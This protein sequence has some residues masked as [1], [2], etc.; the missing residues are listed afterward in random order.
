MRW[1]SV[2]FASRRPPLGK[3]PRAVRTVAAL[4]VLLLLFSTTRS[5]ASELK[6]GTVRAWDDYVRTVNLATEER[7]TGHSPFLWVDESPDLVRRVRGGEVLV[8]GY[9]LQKVSH[10]LIHHWIGAMFLP[11]VTLDD[12]MCVVDDYD[13]YADYYR[14]IVMKSKVF[15]QTDEHEKATLTMMQKALGVTAAVEA[16]EEI[17]TVKLDANRIYSSRSSVR[18]QE[19]ANYGRSDERLLP[20]GQGPGYV[21][22]TV[23]ITRLEQRDGGVYVEMEAIVL[24]RGIP[25]EFLW[26][27]KPLTEKL[28]RNI[29]FDML[30]DTG[31]AV[32]RETELTSPKNQ[33]L[34]QGRA[35]VTNGR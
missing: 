24:S 18:V 28:P 12:V 30:N 17:H 21:W 7:T 11:N 35:P 22:R 5:D 3:R 19:I 27:I 33:I 25:A 1:D 16:D 23:G 2:V 13:H 10:G 34:A 29:M 6:Q 8:A 15:E 20:E 4:T 9:D 31:A 26:L 14:P 32:R